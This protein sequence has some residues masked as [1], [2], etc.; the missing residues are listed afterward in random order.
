M[1]D[2]HR[3]TILRAVI[4]AGSVHAAA[5]NLHF[6]PATISQ[7]LQS[8][9]RQTGLVLF[10]KNGRGIEA[11]PAARH[12]ADASEDALVSLERLERTVKDLREG[13]AEQIAIACFASVAQ[14]WIPHVVTELRKTSPNVVVEV[15]ISELHPTGG[16]RMPDVDVRNEALDAPGDRLEGYRR[17]V[18]AE[19]DFCVV[20]PI[21]HVLA[22]RQVISL[23]EL[24]DQPWIDHDIH[25]G[26]TGQI[27]ASACQS[28]GFSPRYVARLDDHHAAVSLAAAGLGITVLPRIAVAGLP[29][30]LTTRPLTD[31]TVHRRIVAH[32][33][34]RPTRA[35]LIHTVLT[36]LR[37]VAQD[38]GPDNC[39]ASGR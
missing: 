32:T 18:L 14:A 10:E 25:D 24:R 29:A 31:P 30:A 17:N 7:H 15:S 11:T 35:R 22:G 34:T 4:A 39:G 20:L 5:R 27:L 37:E 38:A 16:R 3:L 26:P 1:L 9:A 23:A 6:A 28:A 8:L 36:A 12:L 13:R 2:P 21:D 33:R 19:E